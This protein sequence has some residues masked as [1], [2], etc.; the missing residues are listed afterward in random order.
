MTT[1]SGLRG[2]EAVLFDMDGTLVLTEDR[3]DRAVLRLLAA[4]GVDPADLDLRR[5]HGVTWAAIEADLTQRWPVLGAIHVGAALQREF[6]D[7]FLSDPPA[8]V[9]GACEAVAA[10]AAVVPTAIVTSSN[11]ET[12]TQVC[13][14]LQLHAL[15]TV[16]VAAEDCDRP[17]PDPEPFALGAQRL[18]VAP[19]RCLVFE[20]S[21]AGVRAAT[22]AG[23]VVIAIGSESG[24]EPWIP[25]YRSLPEDFFVGAGRPTD[26]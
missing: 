14:Q 2:V 11:R 4:H 26:A 1:W 10:A 22:S 8:P 7:S 3:T 17:K 18:G 13:D 5:F 25:D 15:V 9:P 19:E 12:L 16:S 23:A 24:H 20:D 21:A 6:H